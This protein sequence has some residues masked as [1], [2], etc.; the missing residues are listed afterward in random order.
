LLRAS[1]EPLGR[2][3]GGRPIGGCQGRVRRWFD[4]HGRSAIGHEA[5]SGAAG[6]SAD[7]TAGS[8]M[9]NMV[10]EERFRTVANAA[11]NG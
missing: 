4:R 8:R 2:G 3:I 7:G 9:V 5:L 11:P 10:R 1:P 6:C